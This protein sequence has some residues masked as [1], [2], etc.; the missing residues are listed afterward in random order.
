MQLFKKTPILASNKFKQYCIDS[1]LEKVYV[2]DCILVEWVKVILIAI[3]IS[4]IRL[5]LFKLGSC[6]KV[7]LF[8][9]G[10]LFGEFIAKK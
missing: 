7:L 8:K 9:N 6:I 3:I 5:T 1:V 4:E 10:T 2:Q